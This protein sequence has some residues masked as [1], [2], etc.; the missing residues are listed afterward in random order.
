MFITEDTKERTSLFM[1]KW[2]LFCSGLLIIMMWKVNPSAEKGAGIIIKGSSI[3]V[4][5]SRKA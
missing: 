2:M 4:I 5:D 1:S 3:K